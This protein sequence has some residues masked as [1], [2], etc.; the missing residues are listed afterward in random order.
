VCPT[1]RLFAN[2]RKRSKTYRSNRWSHH[3]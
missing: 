2:L 1:L 3:W